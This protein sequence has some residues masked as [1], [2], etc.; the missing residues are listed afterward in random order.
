MSLGFA[1]Q[2]DIH[3]SSLMLAHS[4][5]IKSIV[6]L[7][8]LY[9]TTTYVGLPW[10]LSWYRIHLQCR[11][12]WFNSWVGKIPLQYSWASLVAHIV[13]NL[14]AM[15]ETWVRSLSW[16]DPLEEGMATHSNILTWRITMDRG[17]WQVTVHG[18]A[19]SQPRLSHYA[20]HSTTYISSLLLARKK[21][22]TN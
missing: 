4:Y 2:P 19:E 6:C 9:V 1:S 15:Q 3:S 7:T 11:R 13:K 20:Q 8:E 12:P 14:P 22:L 16:K 10:Q 5:Q 21:F 18:V 17:A